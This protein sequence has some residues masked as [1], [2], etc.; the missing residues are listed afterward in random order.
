MSHFCTP[1]FEPLVTMA[2]RVSSASAS[3]VV[4]LEV[5]DAPRARPGAFSVWC[6]S[7]CFTEILCAYT[8]WYKDPR[9]L[10]SVFGTAVALVGLIVPVALVL[11]SNQNRLSSLETTVAELKQQSQGNYRNYLNTQLTDA[12]FVAAQSAESV[13]AA[14]YRSIQSTDTYAK[15]IGTTVSSMNAAVSA[16]TTATA[17]L[18]G[19]LAAVNA[20]V[21]SVQAVAGSLV[22]AVAAVNASFSN[23]L[24]SFSGQVTALNTTVSSVA[25]AFNALPLTIRDGSL[26]ATVAAVNAS[27]SVLPSAISAV[28]ASVQT[29]AGSVVAVVATVS[30]V[31]ASV[32]GLASIVRTVNGSVS[33]V[34]SR[35]EVVETRLATPLAWT[36][37]ERLPPRLNFNSST[38]GVWNASLV[39]DD[40]WCALYFC[41]VSYECAATLVI[42]VNEINASSIIGTAGT[43]LNARD[44]ECVTL[45]FTFSGEMRTIVFKQT[46]ATMLPCRTDVGNAF[47]RCFS[48]NAVR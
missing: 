48:A 16:A 41:T 45:P 8:E 23:R 32:G 34:G 42:Y 12:G 18:S 37:E 24:D 27:V 7:L 40:S 22:A 47:L 13:F 44:A 35:V 10:W 28:N 3:R 33:V 25:V 36:Q 6:L 15:N 43:P 17:A 2:G 38:D 30:A 4:A 26:V 11:Q 19:Q 14:V 31:N 5:D 1:G 9:F 29:V 39:V 46:T 20:T 21:S